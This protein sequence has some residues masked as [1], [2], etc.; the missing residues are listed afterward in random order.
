MARVAVAPRGSR[1]QGCC[2][3]RALAGRETAVAC[4][5]RRSRALRALGSRMAHRCKNGQWRQDGVDPIDNR[6]GYLISARCASTGAWYRGGGLP[7]DVFGSKH[8]LDSSLMG[9]AA[10]PLALDT[11]SVARD[12]RR[13]WQESSSP[14]DGSLCLHCVGALRPQHPEIAGQSHHLGRAD[15]MRLRRDG[16][17][18][19]SIDLSVRTLSRA[20]DPDSNKCN[21][22]NHVGLVLRQSGNGRRA[23]S[24][25]GGGNG[26]ATIEASTEWS[27]TSTT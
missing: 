9:S 27:R 4:G 21:M 20:A 12:P 3:R 26:R 22:R 24:L 5:V 6:R 23:A 16:R 25:G 8:A 19:A 14:D 7:F 10:R 13:A 17:F 18:R 1:S 11:L 15:S 2:R